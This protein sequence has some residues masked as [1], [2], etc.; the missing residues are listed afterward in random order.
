MEEPYHIKAA[1]IPLKTTELEDFRSWQRIP[2]CQPGNA[3]HGEGPMILLALVAM[4]SPLAVG[5]NGACLCVPISSLSLWQM[6]QNPGITA[7]THSHM[8]VP[9]SSSLWQRK[10]SEPRDQSKG[11]R[12]SHMAPSQTERSLTG[13]EA[14]TSV[15]RV[16]TITVTH[17]DRGGET[18]S[19]TE[20]S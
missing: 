18:C 7:H 9:T 4:A 8:F 13:M 1:I 5:R 2:G 12:A 16:H 17:M 14:V 11:L 15:L 10:T 3:M 19:Y 20:N 6:P